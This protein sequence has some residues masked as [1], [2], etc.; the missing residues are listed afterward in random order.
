MTEYQCDRCG[1]DFDEHE[2]ANREEPSDRPF[3]VFAGQE[4]TYLLC[5]PEHPEDVYESLRPGS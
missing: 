3:G 2:V 5:P 1:H 4:W